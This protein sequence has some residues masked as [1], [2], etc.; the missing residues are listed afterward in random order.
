[1][2]DV[3]FRAR[4]YDNKCPAIITECLLLDPDPDL[5]YLIFKNIL[6]F[7]QAI[8][9]TSTCQEKPPEK[10]KQLFGTC[11]YIGVSGSTTLQ[12]AVQQ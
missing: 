12:Q 1:M 9:K 6:Y 8:T 3:D 11:F 10:K 4:R 7:I 2:G 5:G